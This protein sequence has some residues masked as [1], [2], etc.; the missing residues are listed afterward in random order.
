MLRALRAVVSAGVVSLSLAACARGMT[1]DPVPGEGAGQGEGAGEGGSGGAG[2]VPAGEAGEAGG[3]GGGFGE[4]GGPEDTRG[5]DPPPLSSSSATCSD[6]TSHHIYLVTPDSKFLSFHPATSELRR[7][8]RLDCPI[9]HEDGTWAQN[10]RPISM[11]V[12]RSGVAWILDVNGYVVRLDIATGRCEQ[13]SFTFVEPF[14]HFGMAFASDGVPGKETLHV[15]EAL[16]NGKTEE[17]AVRVLGVFDTQRHTITSL[18]GGAG[19]DADLTGTGDGRLFGFERGAPG[20]TAFLSEYTRTTG[21]T[22]ARTPLPGLAIHEGATWA[23]A[24]WGGDFWFFLSNPDPSGVITSSI[25]RFDPGSDA[26]PAL[27]R[28]DLTV[29]IIGAGVST[30]APIEVPH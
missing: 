11:A 13:T 22:R 23:F 16:L 19:G 30:C 5:W 21:A 12:D 9:T 26:P 2:G 10:V 4:G 8:G 14:R 1:L 24:T 27:V 18:G 29:Q 7:I 6:L 20:E 3:G 25:H 15:R 17:D 28:D